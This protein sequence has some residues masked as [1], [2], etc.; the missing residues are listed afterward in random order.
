MER[1][2]QFDNRKKDAAPG[3]MKEAIRKL[4]DDSNMKAAVMRAA[5]D[6]L[7]QLV[8]ENGFDEKD[9]RELTGDIGELLVR[10]DVH[11]L[12]QMAVLRSE[13]VDLVADYFSSVLD[14][15]PDKLAPM[16]ERFRSTLKNTLPA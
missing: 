14:L 7:K 4:D 1:S 8:G 13:A 6:A 2:E 10:K 11:D 16:L 3:G 5:G 15:P 12:L 9:A